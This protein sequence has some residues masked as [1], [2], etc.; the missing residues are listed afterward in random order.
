MQLDHHTRVIKLIW[1]KTKWKCLHN[2]KHLFV[3][4]GGRSQ[5]RLYVLT[6]RCNE[7]RAETSVVQ[8]SL[9]SDSWYHRV[10]DTKVAK[11][12]NADRWWWNGEQ[13]AAVTWLATGIRWPILLLAIGCYRR[14]PTTTPLNRLRLTLE[15]YRSTATAY[16][17]HTCMTQLLLLYSTANMR[18]GNGK[19]IMRKGTDGSAHATG[20]RR[21]TDGNYTDCYS[22]ESGPA[23]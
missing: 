17:L 21:Y 16:A 2:L 18:S 8:T 9:H 10:F 22:G 13:R 3:I 19:L 23:A 1:S 11:A 12:R 15:R 20:G 5:H 14:E 6:P 4:R 7:C